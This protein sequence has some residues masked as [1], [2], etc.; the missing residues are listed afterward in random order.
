VQK[1]VAYVARSVG[2]MPLTTSTTASVPKHAI[3]AKRRVIVSRK[4]F[5]SDGGASSGANSNVALCRLR[6]TRE[7]ADEASA[8]GSVAWSARLADCLVALQ[9][10]RL[11][12]EVVLDATHDI[13]ADRVAVAHC[14]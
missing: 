14:A 11:E 7:R 3:A 10:K 13:V 5:Q 6:P 1:R 12:I 8:T 9:E 4:R 2:G